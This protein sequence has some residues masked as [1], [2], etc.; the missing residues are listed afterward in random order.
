MSTY[1]PSVGV[2]ESRPPRGA[3][4]D[5]RRTTRHHEKGGRVETDKPIHGYPALQRSWDRVT[6]HGHAV[7]LYFY[8]HVFVSHP[9]VRPMFPLSMSDQRDKFVSALGR[10]VSHVDQIENDADFLRA[11]RSR[12][13]QVRAS[14]RSTTTRSVRPCSRP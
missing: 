9:E 8:S 3:R 11:P 13:P 12:P 6:R 2:A 5:R 14:S 4:R 10:I 1:D 7:P